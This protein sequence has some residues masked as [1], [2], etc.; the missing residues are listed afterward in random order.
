LRSA[1]LDEAVDSDVYEAGNYSKLVGASQ[2][3]TRPD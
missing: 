1:L 3:Q 2:A